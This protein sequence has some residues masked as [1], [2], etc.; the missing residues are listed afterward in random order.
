MHWHCSSNISTWQAL[1]QMSFGRKHSKP[2][3]STDNFTIKTVKGTCLK[4]SKQMTM[5]PKFYFIFQRYWKTLYL[6]QIEIHNINK[7]ET[8]SEFTQYLKGHLTSNK[9]MI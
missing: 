3:S 6:I 8:C 9:V 1:C 5:T 7:K 4:A 2:S